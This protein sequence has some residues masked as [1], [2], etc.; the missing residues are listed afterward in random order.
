MTKPIIFF[1]HSGRDAELIKAIK[2]RINLKTG[3]S[4]DIF[5]SSDGTSIR[6]GTNWVIEVERNLDNCK[7]MFVFMTPNSLRSEWIYFESGHAYSN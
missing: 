4:L 2:D 5:L 3:N 6:G 1:S 7:L